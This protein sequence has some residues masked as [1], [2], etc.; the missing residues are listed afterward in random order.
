[1]STSPSN[2][3][4]SATS[5]ADTPAAFVSAALTAHEAP[6][7]AYALTLTR[8]LDLAREATRAT[9]LR[10][11]RQHARLA[12]EEPSAVRAW[13]FAT[14]RKLAK[15]ARLASDQAAP[16]VRWKRIAG[17]VEGADA[18][19]ATPLPPL[20]QQLADLPTN[21]RE[22]IVFK[23]QQGLS[24]KE[25]ATITGLSEGNIAFLIHTGLQKMTPSSL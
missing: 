7:L 2:S 11:C 25:I 16:E 6:V 13:L 19:A 20:L 3:S 14:C 8:D 17:P 15:P 10:L 12:G 24:Y 1:M 4:T 5:S 9:F 18:P 22:A 23:C 21:Q